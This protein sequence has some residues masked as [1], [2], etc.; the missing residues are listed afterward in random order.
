MGK[1]S[2]MCRLEASLTARGTVSTSEVH[3]FFAPGTELCKQ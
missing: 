2:F 3:L 1:I